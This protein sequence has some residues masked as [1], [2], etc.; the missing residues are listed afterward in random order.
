MLMQV[1]SPDPNINEEM[2]GEIS[3]INKAIYMRIII[4]GLNKT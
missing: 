2:F 1:S 3:G 4:H